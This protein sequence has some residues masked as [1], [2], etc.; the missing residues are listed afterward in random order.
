[1][2]TFWKLA[3][4]RLRSVAVESSRAGTDTGCVAGQ[5]NVEPLGGLICFEGK[6]AGV[7]WL[8][9][10]AAGAGLVY[11]RGV[12]SSLTERAGDEGA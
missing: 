6:P 4:N 5:R 8:K 10:L 11:E 12:Q 1:V 7:R 9:R 3:H 2:K